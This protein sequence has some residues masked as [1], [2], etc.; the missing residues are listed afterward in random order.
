MPWPCASCGS[1]T[2]RSRST[3]DEHGD[4]SAEFCPTCKPE[5]FEGAFIAP[6]DQKIW[7]GH[8]AMP[9]LYKRGADDVYRAK[10]E[11]IADTADQW[12][13]GP[14]EQARDRKRATRRLEPLTQEEIDAAVRWGNECLAPKV[15]AAQD[16]ASPR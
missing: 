1:E 6:S 4:L 11:L 5:L 14:T 8:E 15:K 12:D 7:P 13:K 9:N 10:D 2:C 16:Q 3:Y